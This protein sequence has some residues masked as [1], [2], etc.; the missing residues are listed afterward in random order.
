MRS[1]AKKWT[2]SNKVRPTNS[3]RPNMDQRWATLASRQHQR[4]FFE[5]KFPRHLILTHYYVIIRK[6]TQ[7][8]AICI[9]INKTTQWIP[10]PKSPMR[11][12]AQHASIES[13]PSDTASNKRGVQQLKSLFGMQEKESKKKKVF[14]NQ[15]SSISGP[16]AHDSLDPIIIGRNAL[17]IATNICN[18]FLLSL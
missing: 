3:H 7:N 13:P 10:N 4:P 8:V 9:H 6:T 16:I 18:A 14:E 11:H 15:A 1:L 17:F 12:V 2:L 5:S